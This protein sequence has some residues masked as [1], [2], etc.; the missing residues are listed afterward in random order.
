MESAG[1]AKKRYVLEEV[2]ETGTNSTLNTQNKIDEGK[3]D[4]NDD[5]ENKEIGSNDVVSGIEYY[6]AGKKFSVD[7]CK[8]ATTKCKVC[9]KK[10]PK[11]ELRIG[12]CVPFKDKHILQYYHIRCVFK[13][14]QKAR[15]ATNVISSMDDIDGFDLIFDDDKITLLKLIVDANAKRTRPLDQPKERSN[16]TVK[17]PYPSSIGYRSQLLSIKTPSI[18][19]MYTNADQLTPSKKTELIKKIETQKPMLIAICEVK[20]KN[21]KERSILDYKISNYTLHPLN[22][23][24]DI[25]RGIALYSHTSI[26]RSVI[27]VKPEVAF[28]EVCM[29]EIRLRGGDTLLLGC[30]YRSPTETETSAENNYRLNRLLRWVSEKK[31]SHKCIMG[32]FNYGHINWKSWTTT[33]SEKSDEAYFLEALRDS[34]F[35]QQVEKPTRRRGNDEP[36]LLDLVLTNET[37]QVSN[38]CH[39]SPLGKS[40]HDILVLDY[41]AYLDYT[42]PKEQYLYDKGKYDAMRDELIKSNWSNEFVASGQKLNVEEL[43]QKLKSKLHVLRSNYV[44]KSAVSG[45][46]TWKKGSFPLDEVTRESIKTKNKKHR[47][48]M[49][50]TTHEERKSAQQEY[51][52]ARNRANSLLRKAKRS[53]ERGIANDSK[54]IP[55]RFWYHARRKLKTKSGISPLLENVSDK[56]SLKY[57]DKEKAEIL[58]KQFLSVFTRERDGPIPALPPRTNAAIENLLLSEDKVKKRLLKLNVNKS[59]GPD[60]IHPRVL[61]ELANHISAPVTL[62]FNRSIQFGNLPKELK[63]A[64]ISPIFKQGSRSKAENYRP[65][66]LTCILCKLLESMVREEVLKH[67]LDN[68]VLSKRQYGFI[69]GK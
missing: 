50:V 28:D 61:Q 19:I 38:L 8:R 7:Y 24:N 26:D 6:P 31:H 22:L 43:W 54:T 44:P 5:D 41:H 51:T 14:F 40:D 46:L 30:C 60:D 63:E 16:K 59:L 4:T 10:I 55:K 65:I 13:S 21:S 17:I 1:D 36:S 57:E 67:L 29:L 56:E 42:K 33:D 18:K 58:Q 62:I 47:L 66:S 37:L 32:D 12:K 23:D 2:P 48:W 11:D 15:V 52:K 39:I 34:Y 69:N 45:K 20:P 64:Y 53:Y 27:Q 25:G 9:K 35:Y 68:N 3:K 49:N